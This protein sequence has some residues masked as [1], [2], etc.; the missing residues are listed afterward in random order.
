LQELISFGCSKFLIITIDVKNGTIGVNFT[1]QTQVGNFAFKVGI[2]E[3]VTA[4]I[5]TE[6]ILKNLD[7]QS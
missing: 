3:D 1:T 7:F 4:T 5:S 6:S 2:T